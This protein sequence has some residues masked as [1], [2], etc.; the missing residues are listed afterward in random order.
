MDNCL[1][2]GNGLNRC[3]NGG[4]PWGDLLKA[5]AEHLNVTYNPELSMP[6]EFER[7]INEYLEKNP[8]DPVP[9]AIYNRVKREIA[10][11]VEGVKL[12]E[13]A[14]HHEVAKLKMNA[15][16]TTNYDTLLENAFDK[17]YV[18]DGSKYKK[19]LF[20]STANINAS[21]FYHLHGIA[22][23][24]VSLCLGYEHYMGVVQYLRTE[25]NTKKDNQPYQMNIKRVLYNEE[26]PKN[27]WGERFY[28]SN[29]AIIGLELSESEADIWWLLTHRAYLF[30]SNYAKISN[31]LLNSI[32]FYDVVD[33]LPKASQ[34]EQSDQVVKNRVKRNRHKLLA[35]EHVVVKPFVLGKDCDSYEEAYHLIFQDIS[36]NG[37]G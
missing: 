35:N 12:P 10:A 27:T 15:V 5:T 30:Y 37:I 8:N 20:D 17:S 28:T 26:Q 24:P 31:V 11:K 7:I 32:V 13:K 22:N 33:E 2:I 16:L 4:V 1:L 21:T 14:I 29:I 36:K 18:Y 23:S 25:L 9:N 19:Y 6:L 34:K 3:L